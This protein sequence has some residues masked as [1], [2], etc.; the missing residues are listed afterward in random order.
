MIMTLIEYAGF[1]V[2]MA[3]GIEAVKDIADYITT[4]NEDDG[5]AEVF[6]KF[7]LKMIF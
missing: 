2:A 1:G 4:S 7:V 6:E 3:N 5:V